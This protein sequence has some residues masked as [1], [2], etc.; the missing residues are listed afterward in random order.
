MTDQQMESQ[1]ATADKDWYAMRVYMNKVSQCRDLFNIYNN[2]LKGLEE[3]NNR[4]PDEM[5]GEEMEYYAPFYRDYY[6]NDKG[7]EMYREKPLISSL[8]FMR[9]SRKQAEC[10]EKNLM[11]NA[12]LYRQTYDE[13]IKPVI[14]PEKQMRMFIQVSSGN[15]DGLDYFEDGAFSWQKGVRVRVTGGRFEGLEGEIKRIRGDHRLV[16]SIEGICAVATAY[17][18]QCFLQKLD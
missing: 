14:I 10:L 2:V 7:Q 8:F 11:G 3:R 6:T 9:S 4:F 15:Q 17:I 16:V 12:R 18:P 13:V 1:A 5:M